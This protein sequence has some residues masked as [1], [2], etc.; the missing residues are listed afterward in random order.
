MPGHP[1]IKVGAAHK[2][3]VEEWLASLF[4][5]QHSSEPSKLARQIVLLLDGSFAAVLLH[6]DPTYMETAGEAA[7]ALVAAASAGK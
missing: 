1:A 5:E 6:R 2:K 4:E 3:N 7:A